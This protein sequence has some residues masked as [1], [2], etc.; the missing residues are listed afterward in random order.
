MF[1]HWQIR[2]MFLQNAVYPIESACVD[3]LGESQ[4][5][6]AVWVWYG[7]KAELLLVKVFCSVLNGLAILFGC[8]RNYSLM[9]KDCL[10]V[11]FIRS[12]LQ[13]TS[14][15]TWLSTVLDRIQCEL[16][17]INNKLKLIGAWH[18]MILY[19]IRLSVL[20]VLKDVKTNDQHKE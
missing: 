12:E 9:L 1:T 5:D 6:M 19:L 15:I 2:K 20:Y 11:K 4:H 13:S 18:L 16:I 14:W 3:L 8:W 7:L 10:H 17:S